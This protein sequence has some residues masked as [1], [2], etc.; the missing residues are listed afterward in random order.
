M[1]GQH[2]TTP[3]KDQDTA[4]GCPLS[5]GPSWTFHR[6][7]VSSADEETCLRP[8]SHLRKGRC[9]SPQPHPTVRSHALLHMGRL[10]GALWEERWRSQGWCPALVP[11]GQQGRRAAGDW[12]E[13]QRGHWVLES[14]WKKR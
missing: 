5:P 11:R 4:S 8:G 1:W 10:V 12:S 6:L 9:L 3:G 13:E 7:L 14:P 2:M